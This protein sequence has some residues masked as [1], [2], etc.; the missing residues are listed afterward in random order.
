MMGLLLK[1]VVLIS[2]FFPPIDGSAQPLA[3]YNVKTISYSK[4]DF[5]DS[6]HI[7]WEREQIYVPV[8]IEGKHYRFLL[9]TGAAQAVIYTDTPISGC[10]PVGN[11][12]S[13][14]ATGRMDTVQ[15]AVL[16]PITLGT[17]TFSGCRATIQ[18][19]PVQGR[20]FDG[21]IGFD[22]I[23]CGLCAKID[24]RQRLL[25]LTD[26]RY[27]FNGE[28][29]ID[30]KYKLQFHVPYVDV[31]PFGSYHESTLFDTGS[32]RLYA[33]NRQ[34]F[35]VCAQKAGSLIDTQ[36]EGR[37]MGRHTIGLSGPEPLSEVVFLNLSQLRMGDFT[38]SNLH[39]LTT[40]GDSHIGAKVLDYGSMVFNPKKKRIRFQPY[41]QQIEA[42][43][44]NE[45]LDIAFVSENGMPCVGLVWELGEPYRLG[46]RQG[47]IILKI[48]DFI[49]KNFTHFVVWPFVVGREYRFTVRDMSGLSR[50]IRW[51]R[52]KNKK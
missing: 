1:A 20:N 17:V 45:Q 31:S 34:S 33:I 41:H 48:D 29:G 3:R 38:F 13:H 14:D 22:L 44:D 5:V 11:I 21:I 28:Q 37:S 19:R 9:D 52:I 18:S 10:I 32:R 12:R 51:V 49:V 39:T 6:I 46:F 23:N 35:D 50:E 47:D 40:M 2:F 15:M 42:S 4:K 36:V 27:F 16:P 26:R 25:I 8:Q 7:E 43:V 30:M 24:V